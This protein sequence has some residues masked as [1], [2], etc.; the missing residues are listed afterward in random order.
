MT[1]SWGLRRRAHLCLCT[2]MR[3]VG[4]KGEEGNALI[5]CAV[6]LPV[7]LAVMLGATS[8]S[9][10]FYEM[11][12]LG[13]AVSGAGQMLGATAGTI[14]DPC[15]Q[16]VAQVTAALPNFNTG[17]LT[18]TVVITNAAGTTTT[19]GPTQGSLTCKAAGA[20]QAASTA[21]AENEPQ[22]VTVSYK[23]PWMPLFFSKTPT[24]NL[25]STSTTMGE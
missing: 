18:Y 23:Y 20:G 16:V 7:L 24:S 9:M 25:S 13:N 22:T 15:A 21:E 8:F 12:E 6:T 14:T 11:Q 2:L 5:E 17:N 10:A 19:Y 3:A 1:I 4:Y